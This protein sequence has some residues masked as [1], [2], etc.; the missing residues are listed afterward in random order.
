MKEVRGSL[1]RVALIVALALGLSSQAWSQEPAQ[2]PPISVNIQPAVKE[3][4]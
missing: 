3:A 1:L 4:S 2:A